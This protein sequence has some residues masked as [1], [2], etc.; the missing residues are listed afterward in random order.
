[1]ME[2]HSRRHLLDCISVHEFGDPTMFALNLQNVAILVPNPHDRTN[3]EISP[4]VVEGDILGVFSPVHFE[5]I[6]RKVKPGERLFLYT[7]GLLENFSQQV[8]TREEGL[9]ELMTCC[10]ETRDL[11]IGKTVP[12]IITRLQP[13]RSK[14]EDDIV[15]MGIEI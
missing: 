2:V 9:K 1:M 5:V 4:L 13:A 11:P 14:Q 10:Y 3:D 6:K 12:E 15:L 8:R 7:D